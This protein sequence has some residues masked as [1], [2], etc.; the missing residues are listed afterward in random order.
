M[1]LVAQFGSSFFRLLFFF[2]EAN[3]ELSKSDRMQ[4]YNFN[5]YLLRTVKISELT[6]VHTPEFSAACF[7]F[8]E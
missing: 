8:K 2:S 6:F 1:C 3:F 7:I 4:K 5:M